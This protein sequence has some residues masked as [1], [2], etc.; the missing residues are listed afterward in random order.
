MKIESQGFKTELEYLENNQGELV[1]VQ[2]EHAGFIEYQWKDKFGNH[3]REEG[4]E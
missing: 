1:R 4:V 2:M 3:D